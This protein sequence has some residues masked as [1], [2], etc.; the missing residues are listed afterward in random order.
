MK[1]NETFRTY[2]EEKLYAV[3]HHMVHSKTT[4]GRSMGPVTLKMIARRWYKLVVC[5]SR[6]KV[7][8][9]ISFKKVHNNQFE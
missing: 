9:S 5:T 6:R 2:F 1:N 3:K 7:R 8:P 4:S